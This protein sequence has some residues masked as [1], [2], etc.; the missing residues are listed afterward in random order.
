MAKKQKRSAADLLDAAE[1]NGTRPKSDFDGKRVASH[2]EP[3]TQENYDQ[4]MDQWN[5]Y[6]LLY[7]FYDNKERLLLIHPLWSRYARRNEGA[8]PYDLQTLKHFLASYVTGLNALQS[9]DRVTGKKKK[10]SQSTIKMR[11]TCFISAWPRNP[12]NTKIPDTA[13]IYNVCQYS[14]AHLPLLTFLVDE[15]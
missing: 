3:K 14:I 12:E 9:I 5:E 13:S 11:F 6:V 4:M 2:L 10:I 1:L 15:I 7:Q 8:S